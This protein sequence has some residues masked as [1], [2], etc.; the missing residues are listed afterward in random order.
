MLIGIS[1]L[2][3]AAILG[4]ATLR[5]TVDASR[6]E[7]VDAKRRLELIALLSEPK[8]FD[9]DTADAASGL[10]ATTVAPRRSTRRP[11]AAPEGGSAWC[12]SV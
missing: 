4:T 7:I 3:A 2:K 10:T 12:C 1:P 6:R 11:L 5:D 8:R 9:F